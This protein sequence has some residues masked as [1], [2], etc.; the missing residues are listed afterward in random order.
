MR[1]APGSRGSRR[2]T[3]RETTSCDVERTRRTEAPDTSAARD[4]SRTARTWYKVLV[5]EAVVDLHNAAGARVDQ[6]DVAAVADP[7]LI[8]VSRARQAVRLIVVHPIVAAIIFGREPVADADRAI[9][10]A[11][12]AGIRRA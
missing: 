12:R 11:A 1:T 10:I 2:R 3:R 9:A 5:E 6:D 7:A 8:A 4:R